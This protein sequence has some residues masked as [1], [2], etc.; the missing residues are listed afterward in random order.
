MQNKSSKASGIQIKPRQHHVKCCIL[1]YPPQH[2][3]NILYSCK[4]LRSLQS[5]AEISVQ[6]SHVSCFPICNFFFLTS[7]NLPHKIRIFFEFNFW[8]SANVL[9]L[10]AE[11]EMRWW[12]AVQI[13]FIVFGE[14]TELHWG[15]HSGVQQSPKLEEGDPHALKCQG[16]KGQVGRNEFS[17]NANVY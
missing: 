17:L 12:I 9:S 8:N 1:L 6:S 10:S 3:L 14:Y 13:T 4:S 11:F 7:Q 5:F 2:Y 16:K 15:S